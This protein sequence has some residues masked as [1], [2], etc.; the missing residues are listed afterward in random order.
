MILLV[1]WAMVSPVSS[2]HY[3]LDAGPAD[4]NARVVARAQAWLETLSTD[5]M[6]VTVAVGNA[7]ARVIPDSELS[8]MPPESFVVRAVCNDGE[9][10]IGARGNPRSESKWGDRLGNHF[11]L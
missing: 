6:N 3:T 1:F 10:V 5:G 7:S 2:F 9:A 8:E 11:A 4:L